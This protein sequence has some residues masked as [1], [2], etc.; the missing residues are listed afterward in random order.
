MLEMLA[1]VLNWVRAVETRV[2]KAREALAAEGRARSVGTVRVE[3]V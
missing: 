3:R 1:R 2:V